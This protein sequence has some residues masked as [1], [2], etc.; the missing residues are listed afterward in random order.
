VYN[1]SALDDDCADDYD[2][3]HAED[4][5]NNSSIKSLKCE[6]NKCICADYYIRYNEECINS[7]K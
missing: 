4:Y 3:Y 7:G 6:A 2:C 1:L 5:V